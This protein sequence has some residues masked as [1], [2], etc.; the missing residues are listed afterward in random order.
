MSFPF[1]PAVGISRLVSRIEVTMPQVLYYAAFGRPNEFGLVFQQLPSVRQKV[2]TR[3]SSIGRVGRGSNFPSPYHVLGKDPDSH[4]EVNFLYRR[5]ESLMR[6]HECRQGQC[7]AR[8]GS[9]RKIYIC[10]VRPPPNPSAHFESR[11]NTI[12][13]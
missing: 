11:L 13:S 4:P 7:F 1:C 8:T 3:S 6:C 9:A 10:P 5:P 12:S 2:S